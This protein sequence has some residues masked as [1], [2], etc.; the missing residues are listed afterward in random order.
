MSS[1]P[2]TLPAMKRQSSAALL[3][4]CLLTAVGGTGC[5]LVEALKQTG[6]GWNPDKPTI[7]SDR[8]FDHRAA[9]KALKSEHAAKAKAEMDAVKYAAWVLSWE[10]GP[11]VSLHDP[12]Q[13][14]ITIKP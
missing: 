2:L 12:A 5:N 3:C 7:F 4:L 9:R 11:P 1:F 13:F 10:D 6:P 8:W 14:R